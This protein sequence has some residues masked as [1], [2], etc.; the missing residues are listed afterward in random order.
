MQASLDTYITFVSKDPNELWKFLG[1]L[2]NSLFNLSPEKEGLILLISEI[3]HQ[4]GQKSLSKDPN[5]LKQIFMEFFLSKVAEQ[6]KS[7]LLFSKKE[8]L[9]Q[10]LYSFCAPT[11]TARHQMISSFKE[12]V[13]DQST[14]MQTLVVL[15]RFEKYYGEANAQLF[16]NFLHYATLNLFSASTNL[17]TMS[18]AIFCHTAD[19][20]QKNTWWENKCLA[21]VLFSKIIKGIINSEKYQNLV[22]NPQANQK[23]FR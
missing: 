20:I 1:F 17:R 2:F 14:F 12:V 13:N 8:V 23:F 9:I 19:Q 10:L 5:K 21:I 4:F 3:I 15:I 11:P 22:V 7:C 6:I 16:Q 18:L